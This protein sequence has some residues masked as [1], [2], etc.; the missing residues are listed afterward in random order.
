MDINQLE[1]EAK[2][3]VDR[4]NSG[5]FK[6]SRIPVVQIWNTHKLPKDFPIPMVYIGFHKNKHIYNLDAHQILKYIKR[7]RAEF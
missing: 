5:S 3:A 4:H 6:D 1:K 7:Y 2:E